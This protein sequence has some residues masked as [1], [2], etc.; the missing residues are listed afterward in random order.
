[1]MNK[2]FTLLLAAACFSATAQSDI[3]Y[4]YNPDFENDGFVGIE[5]VLE[6]LSVYGTPFTPEQLLLD[7]ASLTEIIESLQSQ[8]D[9]LASY[10]NEGFGAIA[11]ND[12]LL[13]EY[14]VGVAAASEEGDSTLGAWVMQL[15]EVVEQQ[16][17]QIDSLLQSEGSG[18]LSTS[19]GN[20][21]ELSS[22]LS[23]SLN[24]TSWG[25]THVAQIQLPSSGLL[26]VIGSAE[27]FIYEDLADV[28]LTDPCSSSICIR[29]YNGEE[30]FAIPVNSGEW[31]YITTGEWEA[32]NDQIRVFFSETLSIV[33]DSA[34]NETSGVSLA[35]S[36]LHYEAGAD[37][38]IE[39]VEESLVILVDENWYEQDVWRVEG[40]TPTGDVNI[41]GVSLDSIAHVAEQFTVVHRVVIGYLPVH[42]VHLDSCDGDEFELRFNRLTDFS[43]LTSLFQPI[44]NS[45]E[46]KSDD[47]E[48]DA[49][50][51][52][53]VVV[54]FQAA[55]LG[56]RRLT[57]R[58][59]VFYESDLEWDI[60]GFEGGSEG[61]N[62]FYHLEDG[63]WVTKH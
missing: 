45:I 15:S 36:T 52:P 11:L 56:Y 14:L 63:G 9:S 4:P 46:N 53:V 42:T 32:N 19:L 34:G 18:F 40:V 50:N 7:G 48:F 58:K 47:F 44:I 55:Q 62:A 33:D 28:D 27:C 31:L 30:S 61:R 24:S 37:S 5:D 1:M 41:S 38:Y 59:A 12:S 57:H 39:S 3:D 49:R 51:S 21:Q 26:A 17:G 8:I 60:D 54:Q 16:Q 25:G 35:P 29:S 22:E 23:Y 10:T 6:L 20:R 13:T 43:A 2:F